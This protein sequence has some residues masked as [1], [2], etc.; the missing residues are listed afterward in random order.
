MWGRVRAL[1]Q[2]K[3]QQRLHVARRTIRADNLSL[4]R[5]FIANKEKKEKW[6]IDPDSAWHTVWDLLIVFLLAFVAIALPIELAFLTEDETVSLSYWRWNRFIDAAF[7]LDMVLNFFLGYEDEKEGHVERDLRLISWKYFRTWFAVD[8]VSVMPFFLLDEDVMGGVSSTSSEGSI[9]SLDGYD[10][11]SLHVLNALRLLRVIKIARLLRASRIVKRWEDRFSFRSTVVEPIKYVFLLIFVIHCMACVLEMVSNMATDQRFSWE[12]F[13]LADDTTASASTKYLSAL[14]WSCMTV[15]TVGYGDLIPRNIVETWT[16]S[17]IV[18]V[19]SCIYAYV[20]G[21]IVAS[22]SGA[23]PAEKDFQRDLENLDEYMHQ[24]NCTTEH[25]V[26]LRAFF[27]RRALIGKDAYFKS[28]L[29]EC[30]PEI[31]AF[32]AALLYKD[33]L[34]HI[35][36]MQP[37]KGTPEHREH[38]FIGRVCMLMSAE[39]FPAHEYLITK[40]EGTGGQSKMFVIR[41]GLVGCKGRVF[42]R[43]IG[44]NVLGEDIICLNQVRTYSARS[45]TFVETVSVSSHALHGLLT[46]SGMFAA[47]TRVIRKFA[48][49]WGFRIIMQLIMARIKQVKMLASIAGLDVDIGVCPEMLFAAPGQPFDP[50]RAIRRMRR[51]QEKAHWKSLGMSVGGGFSPAGTP[52]GSPRNKASNRKSLCFRA[53]DSPGSTPRSRSRSSSSGDGDDD[54][55]HLSLS[56]QPGGLPPPPLPGTAAYEKLHDRNGLTPAERRFCS[57]VARIPVARTSPSQAIAILRALRRT[58]EELKASRNVTAIQ[59]L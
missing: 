28:V 37:P 23:N 33:S 47:Q 12:D 46:D 19:G 34:M 8:F 1:R 31:Q 25:K 5:D 17:V 11:D 58:W 51:A 29:N 22:L 2:R 38:H 42:S 18:F 59:E 24:A 13:Y 26:R 49:W 4:I 45:L 43:E 48:R 55:V 41:R 52:A 27:N 57:T 10:T 35:P 16:A 54:A 15:T 44:K 6:S 14:Y 39:A 20:V 30:S 53:S 56:L 32:L 50:A 21:T 36:F 3:R 9:F 40:G 7:L